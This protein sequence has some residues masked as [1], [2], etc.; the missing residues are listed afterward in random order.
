MRKNMLIVAALVAALGSGVAMAKGGGG[1]GGGMQVA[2][3][4][5][6]VVAP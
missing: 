3:K 6:R 4:A 1:G 5:C 2:C